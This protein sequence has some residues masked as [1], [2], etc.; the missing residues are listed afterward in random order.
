MKYSID[1]IKNFCENES[2]SHSAIDFG[3]VSS[4]SYEELVETAV[5]DA[6]R[7]IDSIADNSDEPTFENTI[8]ALEDSGYALKRILGVYYALLSACSNEE[9]RRASYRIGELVSDYE[10]EITLNNK[11]WQRIKSI[12]DS[13]EK[14]NLDT[15]S[16]TL[17]QELYDSF[18]RNGALLEGEERDELK[19]VNA[20]L[21]T[22]TTKFG[23]NVL[24]D[25]ENT[26][27]WTTAEDVDGLP[28]WLITQAHNLANEKGR[29]GELCFSMD[30]PVYMA[31]MQYCRRRELREKMYRL[32]MGRNLS[33]DTDNTPLVK[34]IVELRLKKAR[35]LGYDNCADMKL[36]SRMAR[37][38]ERVLELLN[39]LSTAY[40][41]AQ[42]KE[43]AELTEFAHVKGLIDGKMMPWDYSYIFHKAREEKYALNDEELREYFELGAVVDGVF[44]LASRLYGLKF[45]RGVNV[46]VYYEDVEVVDVLDND[47]TSL[48]LLYM[49]F[50]PR[51][52]KRSGAWMTDFRGQWKDKNG[53]DHRPLISIVTNFTKPV[54]DRPSL[55]TPGE[56]ETLLHE[57]GHALHGL[58]T[59]CRYESLS[60][61][62]VYRDFVELPSMFNESFM[63]VPE[64]VNKFARH[65]RTGEPM[66][67]KLV[68]ALVESQRYGSAYACMRQLFFGLLDM[69]WH[70]LT[71]SAPSIDDV[72]TE[73]SA[74]VSPF[75]PVDGC[76]TSVRF[77]HIFSGGYVAGYYGYKWAEVHAADAFDAFAEKGYF[78]CTVAQ[79]FRQEILERG[80]SERP[81]ILYL[82]FRGR[83]AKI[84]AL[85]ARDGIKF[86]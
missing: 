52:G 12:Y 25:L 42:A 29:E 36:E 35:L 24:S 48:G 70:T 3:A 40:A 82:R 15:E 78:D 34:E 74:S 67:D 11:L 51:A 76:C 56:V 85:L 7:E 18:R 66:P 61:T 50:L 33:G 81:E 45:K 1:D 53:V 22:L 73:V 84:D 55:L 32:Y 43:I 79:R 17:L 65:W 60:G 46:P 2:L 57:F 64:F 62:N 44:A 58:L 8:V 68:C 26:F 72:E 5:A 83:D 41:P 21:T 9:L 20:R 63:R 86:S 23:D 80:G 28:E 13:G 30:Q 77:T 19:R 4:D 27:L 54:G 47:G 75:P 14:A 69:R 59:R 37:N 38:K 10:S 31:F 49:D 16:A 39:S 71:D 6:R